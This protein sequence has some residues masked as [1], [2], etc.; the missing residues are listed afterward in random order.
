MYSNSFSGDI[1]AGRVNLSTRNA[2]GVL[3]RRQGN[4]H[5]AIPTRQVCRGPVTD[6]LDI[7]RRVL[8]EPGPVLSRSAYDNEPDIGEKTGYRRDPVA[9][10]ARIKMTDIPDRSTFRGSLR[11]KFGD[12]GA[13]GQCE[14]AETRHSGPIPL[15]KCVGDHDLANEVR[16]TT[17]AQFE[18]RSASSRRGDMSFVA[19][20][21]H[22]WRDL[23]ECAHI[24]TEGKV[25]AKAAAHRR[26]P[27]GVPTPSPPGPWGADSYNLDRAVNLKSIAEGTVAHA[28]RSSSRH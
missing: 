1:H 4:V 20:M 27:T 15:C 7:P 11:G 26:C 5:R 12:I 18:R 21:L 23:R 19:H 6:E 10:L 16:L 28:L 14:K 24:A 22:V 3:I 8:S 13:I 2:D 9:A 25:G 17:E